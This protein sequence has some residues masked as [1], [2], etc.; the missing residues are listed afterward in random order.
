MADY[1]K[2]LQQ[3][4]VQRRP[5]AT[6]QQIAA[7]EATAKLTLPAEVKT[8]FTESDGCSIDD[9]L[10]IL[11][12]YEALEL[13]EGM[14]SFG[15]PK[16]WGYFPLT[17]AYDSNP[18]CLCC[19]E[20]LTG[21]IVHVYHDDVA[22]LQFRNFPAFLETITRVLAASPGGSDYSLEELPHDL[23]T[24]TRTAKD[25]ET[26][27]KLLE[28][29]RAGELGEVT[30][31]DA[32][33][34]STTLLGKDQIEELSRMLDEEDEYTRW[35][36]MDRLRKMDTPRARELMD[37]YLADYRE[38][39]NRCAQALRDAK[40]GVEVNEG[41]NVRIDN[42]VWLNMEWF[43]KKRKSP[44]FMDD[45]VKRSRELLGQPAEELMP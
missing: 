13:A 35:D 31:A 4:G 29:A 5:G 8:F 38:F 26:G 23:V 33:R 25:I 16:R 40:I 11:S 17:E 3:A 22:A 43:Y 21:W 14:A 10:K 39:I 7:V 12:L 36:V 2:F 20:P 6:V 44:T 34:W 37:R 28:L 32:L 27:N 15:I 24:E 42:R 30:R 45:F 41:I 9:W 19:K 1:Y 18:Y